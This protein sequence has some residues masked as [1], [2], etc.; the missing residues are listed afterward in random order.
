MIGEPIDIQH[1]QEDDI[2][3][4]VDLWQASGILR[5][6]N[7]PLKDIA[8]ARTSPQATV[9][10]GRSR[11][12]LVATTMVG[13]DGHRGWVYYVATHP[14]F[15][16]Q[17]IARQMM[18]AAEAWLQRRGVWKMQLLIRAE[19]LAA[20]GFYEKLGF[21]DTRTVCLQKVIAGDPS[22]ADVR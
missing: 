14:A 20:R 19:N 9:L 15:Q 6:W 1:I 7:D 10:V 4:V 21:G 16:R 5:P 8:F 22:T 3:G 13:E 2:P 17:G 12:R 18:S 11:D